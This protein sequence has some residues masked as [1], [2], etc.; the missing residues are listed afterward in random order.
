MNPI[1]KASRTLLIGGPARQVG[2]AGPRIDRLAR[3]A[4]PAHQPT[5]SDAQLD[6]AGNVAQ[7][8]A[9]LAATRVEKPTN[10]GV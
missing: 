7:A 1:G 4:L 6:R 10:G 5:G 8:R 3:V 9:Q 2:G